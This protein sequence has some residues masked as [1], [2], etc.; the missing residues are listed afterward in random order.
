MRVLFPP[1]PVASRAAAR[2]GRRWQPPEALTPAEV[3]AVIAAAQGERDRLLLRV[4]W[5]T[6]GRISEVLPL[7]GLDV[8]R[9]ALV[10]PNLKNPARPVKAVFLSAGDQDLPG[11]LLLFQ[12]EQ[13]LPDDAPL[14]GSRTRGTDGRRRALS[15]IQAWRIV[16][17]ASERAG[18]RVL[19][20]RPSKAGR[21]GAPAP[22]HPHLFRHAR[23][24][25]IVRQTRSLP[26]AQ[27]Q[28]GW[29]RLQMAYLTLGDEE[30]RELMR[31]V[32]E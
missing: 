18:V 22:V 10:L 13:G 19:A 29:S 3:R 8:R 2:T 5:A 24:R 14:F 16:K 28:A 30:A 31:R 11:E 9:D 32:E 7:R 1:R 12:R 6:G 20:L 17:A 26:L 4:L 27:K 25:Q 23:V 21:M 15:R